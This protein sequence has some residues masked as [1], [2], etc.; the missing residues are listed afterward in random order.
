MWQLI[1]AR[2]RRSFNSRTLGRVRRI[3]L[4]L[5]KLENNVSIHAP[6]EGCD[7]RR[8]QLFRICL[9]VS[10]HAPWEGCDTNRGE[11][12]YQT[13]RFQFTHPGKGATAK[14][15]GM[16]TGINSFNSRTL[17]RVR[18]RERTTPSAGDTV[19]IHAPWE[20][21]DNDGY[22]THIGRYT[23]QFTHPGKGATITA[24]RL[25]KRV[26]KFQFTHPGKGATSNDADDTR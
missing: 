4:D 10:I 8:E 6:W 21:C 26:Y 20:G 16:N 1:I 7:R 25:S 22:L 9:D 3:F 13:Y 17:G 11:R 2:M 24:F 14:F 15:T 23:F 5:C 19:S 12:T 18:L